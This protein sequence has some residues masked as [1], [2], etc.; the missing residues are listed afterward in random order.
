M[1][2]FYKITDK[3]KSEIFFIQKRFNSNISIIFNPE[4][5]D[6][7]SLSPYNPYNTNQFSAADVVAFAFKIIINNN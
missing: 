4:E 6:Y 7:H 5:A 3:I 2:K 1:D